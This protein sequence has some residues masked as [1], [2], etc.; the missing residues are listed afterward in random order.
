MNE[1]AIE[2]TKIKLRYAFYNVYKSLA[3]RE[4]HLALCGIYLACLKVK[5]D[6]KAAKTHLAVLLI[7][8]KSKLLVASDSKKQGYKFTNG[9]LMHLYRVDHK[10]GIIFRS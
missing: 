2:K 5:S 6:I 3:V 7:F 9:L 1:K 8:R 10:F 4:K